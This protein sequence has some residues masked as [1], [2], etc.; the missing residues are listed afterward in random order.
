ME[1]VRC[2][3]KQ[4]R[5]VAH[6][7]KLLTAAS[8]A[9]GDDYNDASTS[10]HCSPSWSRQHMQWQVWSIL[11]NQI[12]RVI[13]LIVTSLVLKLW[14][15]RLGLPTV[16]ILHWAVQYMMCWQLHDLQRGCMLVF[17]TGRQPTKYKRR[18]S[19]WQVKVL[20]V[21]LLVLFM[22]ICWFACRQGER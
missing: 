14:H 1:A 8:S 17:H 9:C 12:C 21:S 7:V 4:D 19:F 5:C 10:R 15:M 13:S 18:L 6:A 22:T 11:K 20:V 3:A 16:G 2:E